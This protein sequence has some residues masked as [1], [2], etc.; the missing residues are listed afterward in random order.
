MF[1]LQQKFMAGYR[2]KAMLSEIKTNQF[3]DREDTTTIVD[4]GGENSSFDLAKI[5]LNAIL[6]KTLRA[7][8]KLQRI[9]EYRWVLILVDSG[10]THTFIVAAL[11]EELGLAVEILSNFSIQLKDGEIIRCNQVCC[12][13][14]I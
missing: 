12:N 2:C 7:M 6:R 13:A 14:S 11:V 4:Q 10:S 9:L 1:P 8:M 3:E 5:S